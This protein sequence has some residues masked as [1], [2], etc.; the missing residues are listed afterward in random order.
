MLRGCF[1]II[2]SHV[3]LIAAEGEV[4]AGS[5][6]PSYDAQ[7]TGIQS[8]EVQEHAYT[9]DNERLGCLVENWRLLFVDMRSVRIKYL[10]YFTLEYSTFGRQAAA[11]FPLVLVVDSKR[12]TKELHIV[13]FR[14]SHQHCYSNCSI[15]PLLSTYSQIH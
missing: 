2:E 12:R 5:L 8:R 1:F 3:R 15:F 10:K 4:C 6:L 13:L 7:G 11:Y 14:S 9:M